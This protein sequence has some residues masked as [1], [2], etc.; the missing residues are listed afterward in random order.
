[1]LNASLFVLVG[2]E[3]LL[4]SVKPIYAAAAALAIPLVLFARFVSVWLSS[5]V[6]GLV[7]RFSKHSVLILTWG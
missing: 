5:Y 1:M 7:S 2:F 6:A 3:A 4:L